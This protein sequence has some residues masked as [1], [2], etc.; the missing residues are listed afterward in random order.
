MTDEPE[1]RAQAITSH[2]VAKG[3]GTTLLARL[4]AVVEVVA[5]PVYVWLF[6]LA[7]F[8]IYTALWAAITLVETIADLGMTAA[9]QRTVP[10]AE[11]EQKAVAT[12]RAALIMGVLPCIALAA[13][14]SV[15]AADL[16]HIFN[17]AQG[18]AE[19]L[20]HFIAIF[21]WALPLWA[22]V[23]VATSAL[24]ARRVFGAEI[25]LR[26]FWEQIVRLICT[27][28]FWAMG[29]GTMSLFYAHLASLVV[30]CAL[31]IRLLSRN[32]D[33]RLLTAGPAEDRVWHGTWMAGISVMPTILTARLF[34]DA[35][36][37]LLNALLPGAQGAVA[38]G[39]FALVRKVSSLV[40]TIRIAFAY[41]LAPLASAAS[42]GGKAAVENIYAFSTR[43]SLTV[44]LPVCCVLIAGGPTLLRAIGSGMEGALFALALLLLA[45]LAETVS[46]AAAPIQQVMSRYSS[47]Y[48]GS[49]AGLAVSVLIGLAVMPE[50]GLTGMSLAVALGLV[51]TSAI[52]AWQVYQQHGLLPFGQPFAQVALRAMIVS[53]AGFLAALWVNLLPMG[54]ALMLIC[55]VLVATLWTAC[56]WALPLPDREALGSVAVRMRLI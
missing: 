10:Q 22:F 46:G 21:V 18:D 6:G 49:A 14:A 3:A 12:L 38:G 37:L 9:L 31:C 55:G 42:T 32:Y 13:T 2:D 33:L 1:I 48:I 11:T 45:R 8:G 16:A 25:R 53:L 28:G 24:R 20:S 50:G 29:F 47:Q 23:E 41:V 36:T 15:F 4:G 5:Q 43:I 34:S 19:Q 17:A 44:A 54:L 56:R 52:P 35:P 26:L 30:I 51:A 7:S 40:Q 27:I 39:Q